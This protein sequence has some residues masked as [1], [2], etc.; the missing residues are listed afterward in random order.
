MQRPMKVFDLEVLIEPYGQ[1][2]RYLV[3][4]PSL[5]KYLLIQ[6]DAFYELIEDIRGAIL[7]CVE[8]IIDRHMPLR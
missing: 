1:G 6:D 8:D 4:C 5:S 7:L 3:S 2:G